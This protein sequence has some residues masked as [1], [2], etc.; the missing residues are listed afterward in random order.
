MQR[1]EAKTT[2]HWRGRSQAPVLESRH[3]ASK[4]LLPGPPKEPK[5][6]A[7]YPKIESIGSIGSI[8]LAILEVQVD[9]K[10][11]FRADEV[12]S[13]QK[14]ALEQLDPWSCGRMLP[15]VGCLDSP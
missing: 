12:I 9:P 13:S 14:K 8:I 1:D 5:I 11:F 10:L 7:Q 2:S 6:M 3:P 4:T 15:V